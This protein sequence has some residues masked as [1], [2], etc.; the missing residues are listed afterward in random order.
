MT[1]CVGDVCPG[2]HRDDPHANPACRVCGC[3]DERACP[4]GC[5]WV[6]PDLCSDCGDV[7]P[8]ASEG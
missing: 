1:H 4:G 6:E 3:T 7:S 2:G 5:W 8:E